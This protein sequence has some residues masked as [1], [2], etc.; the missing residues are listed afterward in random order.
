MTAYMDEAAPNGFD[1]EPTTVDFR[2]VHRFEKSGHYRV[3]M[4]DAALHGH[5]TFVYRLLI[6]KI[7]PRFEVYAQTNQVSVVPGHTATLPVRVRR[8]GGWDA[9]V[10]V[11][12][13]GLPARVES[14]KM[15][16]EPINTRFR[17][18][19]SEDFFFDGTNVELPLQKRTGAKAAATP[20]RVHARGTFEGRTIEATAAVHYPWQQT[21]YLRGPGQDQNMVL[22]VAQ[23]PISNWTAR[24]R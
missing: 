24:L 18:T 6:G 23:V 20:V 21:G 15:I 12:V 17:G 1:K 3:E 9:P 2:L 5:E 13:D 11:W 16:A 10:E 19:F 22:T 8:F 4:R 7:E 14:K